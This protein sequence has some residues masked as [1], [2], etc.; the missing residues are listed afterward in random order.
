MVELDDEPTEMI[1][2]HHD[3][4]LSDEDELKLDTEV[5]EM[6]EVLNSVDDQEVGVTELED[7]DDGGEVTEHI[8]MVQLGMINELEDEADMLNQ[9]MLHV[10]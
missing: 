8:E 7:D 4:E 1:E 9:H 2:V 10:H 3:I 5:L 6:L